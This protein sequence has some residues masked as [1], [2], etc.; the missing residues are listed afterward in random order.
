MSKRRKITYNDLYRFRLV[1]DARISPDGET[2]LF[3][4]TR[5]SPDKKEDTCQSHIW[6]VRA[7][8]GTPQ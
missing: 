7:G 2:I 1:G 4:L 5:F 3:T 6:H 8:G